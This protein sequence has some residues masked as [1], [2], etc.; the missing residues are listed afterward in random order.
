MTSQ[1]QRGEPVFLIPGSVM[2]LALVLVVVEIVRGRFLSPMTD[3]WVLLTFAFIPARYL[4]GAELPGG[5]FGDLWTF[6]TYAFLHGDLT[7]LFVN[8]L[9]MLAFGTALARRFGTAR[10]LAFSALSAVA[11]AVAHLALHFGE[12]VPVVGASAAISGQM[13]A[14]ARFVFDRGAPL[15]L[16]RQAGPAGY[17]RPAQPLSAVLAN[18]RAL[19]FL[20]V[21]FGINLLVGLSAASGLGGGQAI[22]WEAHIGGFLFGLLAFPLFDPVH[23]A[24]RGT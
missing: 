1:T 8:V 24:A 20:G 18:G 9:W 2:G 13:A 19:A 16:F 22:A 21:W 15:G 6:L 5:V 14:A 4:P 10:F 17:F 3:Y 23:P 11:G 7:H 12:P